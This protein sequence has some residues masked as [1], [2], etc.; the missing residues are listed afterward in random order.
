LALKKKVRNEYNK[1]ILSKFLKNNLERK[2]RIQNMK[3]NPLT[4]RVY[5]LLL[6]FK[7]EVISPS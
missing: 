3:N 2:N 4:R 5:K 1:C 6:K 7:R